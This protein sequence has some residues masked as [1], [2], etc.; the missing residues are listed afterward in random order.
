MQSSR[1]EV[2]GDECFRL[3][4]APEAA[5]KAWRR[6]NPFS[7]STMISG[8]N[9]S[10]WSGIDSLDFTARGPWRRKT[11]TGKAMDKDLTV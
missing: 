5:L 11:W 9:D 1:V 6:V 4:A 10:K 2:P 7:E 3:T 8:Q